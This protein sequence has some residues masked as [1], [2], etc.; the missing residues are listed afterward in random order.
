[1]RFYNIKDDYIEYLRHYDSKVAQNKQESRP[2]VGV[3]L[4]IAGIKYYAPFSS[5]K[6]K[7][8]KMKNGKD[9][10]KINHGLYG[11]INFNNMIPVVDEALILIEIENIQDE[12]YKR[13]LQ[14]Q[15]NSIRSDKTQIEKTAGN[16]HTLVLTTDKQLSKH[17]LSVKQRCCDLSLLESV[18]RNYK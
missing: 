10:R 17:D 13:L 15:Y 5:P 14:N 4:E 2:Y 1:M 16:L 18:Y 3:I 12:K 11:A 8:Q 6:P 9:F 7:H